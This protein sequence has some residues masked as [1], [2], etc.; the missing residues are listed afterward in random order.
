ME[1]ACSTSVSRGRP[2]M[3]GTPPWRGW[4]S[5]F[6]RRRRRADDPSFLLP[7]RLSGR[8]HCL[9]GGNLFPAGVHVVDVKGSIGGVEEQTRTRTGRLVHV[10]TGQRGVCAG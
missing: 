3:H 7:L 1:G 5:I 4:I 2:L 9:V 10:M 6:T 8:P